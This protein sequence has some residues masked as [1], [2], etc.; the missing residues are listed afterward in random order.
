MNSHASV[1]AQLLPPVSY[2]ANDSLL[3]AELASVGHALDEATGNADR[4]LFEM[5]PESC[6]LGLADW[7]RNYGLPDPCVTTIQ[8]IDQRRAALVSKVGFQGGQSIP[9]F[10]GLAAS[11]GFP[12]ATITE[13]TPADCNGTCDSALYSY[14]DSY[15]WLLNIPDDVGG[16]FT[17]NCNSDADSALQSWGNEALECRIKRYRPAYTTVIFSYQS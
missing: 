12:G 2:D 10:I 5:H 14:A 13:F 3:A 17:A 11:I 9:Y 4:L 7:E 6:Q 8:S 15:V 1:L 16:L